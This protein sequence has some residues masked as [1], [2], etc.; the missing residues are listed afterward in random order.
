MKR[1]GIRLESLAAIIEDLN[2]SE[3]L[4]AIFGDP[5]TGHLAIVA[6]YA[7][8]AVDL[9]IEEIRDVPLNDD[10][11]S[12]FVEVTDRIVYANIL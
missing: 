11:N 9:R 5:V 8:G 12:R 2:N 3:E 6:E 7:D 10:E 4:R 1:V